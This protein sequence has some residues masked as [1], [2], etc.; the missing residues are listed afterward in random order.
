VAQRSLGGEHVMIYACRALEFFCIM[1]ASKTGL[2]RNMQNSDLKM[3]RGALAVAV[4]GAP[5]YSVR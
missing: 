1:D 5:L 4:S 3:G 2:V